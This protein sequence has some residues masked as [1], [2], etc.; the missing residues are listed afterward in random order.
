MNKRTRAWVDLLERIFQKRWILE[1][2]VSLTVF[3][4]VLAV[5][6]SAFWI[7]TDLHLPSFG[8]IH[9]LGVKAYWDEGLTNETTTLDWGTVYA[10]STSNV[11]IYLQSTSD[12]RTKLVQ[13]TDNWTF[14]DSN[15]TEVFPPA[16]STPYMELEWS[17]NNEPILPAQV[18]RVT[19]ILK[20]IENPNGTQ[21]GFRKYLTDNMI[22]RF[23]FETYIDSE[24]V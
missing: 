13:R 8:T 11:T 5:L 19:L 20:T 23:K 24:P 9:T 6:L 21:I 12:V 14:L 4:F 3:A 1:L 15:D 17:Y 7:Q 18:L 22:T 2:I 16:E 10:W